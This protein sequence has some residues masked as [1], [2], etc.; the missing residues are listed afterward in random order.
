MLWEVAYPRG[1]IH[2]VLPTHPHS[3]SFPIPS[4]LI[5]PSV[6]LLSSLPLS[7]SSSSHPSLCPPPPPLIPP[8]VLLLLSSLSSLPLSSSSSHP[9]PH[10]LC[11][12]PPL[13]PLL[14]P[15]SHTSHLSTPSHRLPLNN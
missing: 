15:S 10:S 4:P 5:P 9:S 3:S 11:P 14:T 7:S 12:P 6:L 8:S 13:I 2:S 1:S